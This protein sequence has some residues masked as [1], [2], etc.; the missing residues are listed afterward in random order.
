MVSFLIVAIKIIFLL[1]F[2]IFIHELGHY[3]VAKLCK[4]KVNEFALGFGPVI[5]SKQGK[6]TKYQLRLIPLGGF[7]SME[8]EDSRSD[9]D[10]AFNKASIAKRIAIVAAGGLV[11][12]I[13]AIILYFGTQSV[14]G[15]NISTKISNLFPEY[16]AET[17]G[18]LPGDEIIKINGKRVRKQSDINKAVDNS[19]GEELTILINRNG[20]KL[21]FKTKPT[22]VNYKDPGLYLKAQDNTTIAGFDSSIKIDEQGLKRGD[23]IIAINGIDVENDVSKMSEVLQ[24]ENEKNTFKFTVKRKNEEIDVDIIPAN[25]TRYQLGVE[26]AKADKNLANNIYYAFFDTGDFAFSIV[27]N[28]K[29][30]FSGEIK[31]RDLMG[32]VG[33]STVV[34]ESN[35]FQDFLYIMALISLSLGVTNLLP[36]PPLDG[37]K[38]VLLIIE[39]IRRKP[40][41][42]K[43]EIGIQMIG[44]VLM[45][46]LSIYVTYN[47]IFRIFE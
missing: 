47:D 46:M 3:T 6:E 26:L 14:I 44:F 35:G 34:A 2:L 42:E 18:I 12:I 4:I 25:K 38:I 22:G 27:E 23:K 1:G 45:I 7:V 21:E 24:G 29:M 31:T 8:G 19:K 20:S 41:Q 16:A 39:A 9:E 32:P 11:N 17:V 10:R 43:H 5:L 40:L 30:L 15:N 36:F 28:L 37:G 13:F 33:I